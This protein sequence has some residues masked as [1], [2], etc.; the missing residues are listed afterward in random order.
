MVDVFVEDRVVLIL[1]PNELKMIQK[2]LTDSNDLHCQI[3][4]DEILDGKLEAKK[5][6]FDEFRD[7][8]S[9]LWENPIK[10]P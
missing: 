10:N 5:S 9:H 3:L 2:A 4:R 7:S 6:A 8:C 1:S